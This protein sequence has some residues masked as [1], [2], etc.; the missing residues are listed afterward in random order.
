MKGDAASPPRHTPGPE[1]SPGPSRDASRLLV[2]LPRW[3]LAVVRGR[4]RREPARSRPAWLGRP[5]T[6]RGLP[7]L[8]LLVAALT[9]PSSLPAGLAGGLDSTD[10]AARALGLSLEEWDRLQEQAW[11][12]GRQAAA[13]AA[14]QQPVAEAVAN[15]PGAAAPSMLGL[16]QGGDQGIPALALRAYHEAAAW[17]AGFRPGCGLSWSVLA[18]IGRLE[19][20][21]GLH[22]GSAT[23]FRPDGVVSPPITGPALNGR[24]AA[25]IPDTDGGR[26]DGD[27]TWDRAV[28]PMQ[29][30]PSTWRRLGRDGNGDRV[31]DP[32]NLFD[33]ATSAAGY[34]C[35]VGGDLSGREGLRRAVYGYNHSWAYVD[36]V[37]GWASRYEGGVAVAPAGAAGPPVAAAAPPSGPSPRPGPTTAGVSSTTRRPGPAPAITRASP[38]PST[39]TTRPPTSSSATTPSMT[40]STTTV[41]TTT[42]TTPS[43]TTGPCP[44][45]TTSTTTTTPTTTTLPPCSP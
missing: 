16:P 20:N 6:A 31:V 14:G 24:G 41:P 19:S 3:L 5:L 44:T 34:L 42:T 36:A 1:R 9:L 43:T 11:L 45:T 33:A 7:M 25:S 8:A 29:F 40:I 37:L 17:A 27:R 12:R 35:L 39:T 4:R 28:G 13:G 18:G 22:W 15:G 10:E 30:I 23:R 26:W 32:N 38:G 2:R 21:H